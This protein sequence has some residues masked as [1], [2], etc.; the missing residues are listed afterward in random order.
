MQLFLLDHIAIKGNEVIIDDPELRNQ[1]KKVLRL[2]TGDNIFIQEKN[3]RYEIELTGLHDLK[4]FWK[5]KN[6]LNTPSSDK[7]IT[8]MLIAMPNK[9]EKVELIVQKLCEIGIDTIIF[10][11][12]ERSIIKTWNVKKE[13]RLMKIA[14]EALEQSQQVATLVRLP[15][16]FP[17][18]PSAWDRKRGSS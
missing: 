3:I 12:A 15:W 7:P 18:S 13:E 4:I 10:R 9:R 5:V 14:K 2:Q 6:T 1:A 16:R 11:P 8:T 17:K